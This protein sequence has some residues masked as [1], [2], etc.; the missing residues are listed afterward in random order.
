VKHRPVYQFGISNRGFG[1]V[2]VIVALAILVGIVT[3]TVFF[4]STFTTR[5]VEFGGKTSCQGLANAITTGLKSLENSLVV[6][7]WLPKYESKGESI[8]NNEDPFC[9]TKEG[10]KP[11]CDAFPLVA[12]EKKNQG[13]IDENTSQVFQNIRGTPVWAQSMYNKFRNQKICEGTGMVFSRSDFQNYLPMPLEIPTWVID[14]EIYIKD[15][16]L[17]CGD[18]STSRQAN[19]EFQVTPRYREARTPASTYDT[20]SSSITVA[21]LPDARSPIL[22]QPTPVLNV[23]GDEVQP[24]RCTDPRTLDQIAQNPDKRWDEVNFTL[25]VDEP[26]SILIARKD[27][28]FEEDKAGKFWNLQDMTIDGG[29]SISPGPQIVTYNEKLRATLVMGRMTDQ[30]GMSEPSALR[31]Y[32][33]QAIDTG[34]NK[35]GTVTTT[36]YAHQPVCA[37]PTTDYCP[38]AAPALLPPQWDPWKAYNSP[39]A[40]GL[41]PYDDC[42]NGLCPQGTHSICD[43]K[44]APLVCDGDKYQDDCGLAVCAGTKPK[45]CDGV[46]VSTVLCK[47]PAIGECGANCGIGTAPDCASTPDPATVACYQEIKDNC[48]NLCGIGKNNCPPCDDN[49]DPDLLPSCPDDDTPKNK[50]PWKGGWWGPFKCIRHGNGDTTTCAINISPATYGL[51]KGYRWYSVTFNARGH[52]HGGESAMSLWGQAWGASYNTWFSGIRSGR[53]LG[54][55]YVKNEGHPEDPQPWVT[56]NGT[57]QNVTLTTAG[58]AGGATFLFT[59]WVQDAEEDLYFSADAWD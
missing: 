15:T 31:S 38:N 17:K 57:W 19:L 48:G 28:K 37:R 23:K 49:D 6:R 39:T 42:L 5:T 18:E 36:F 51:P 9:S 43:K 33:F 3:A 35:S 16:G 22:T 59:L 29:L 4:S 27:G 21:N 50:P 32:T 20:C 41:R 24:G 2:E 45:S 56:A 26:G 12:T 58:G 47:K 46:D 13:Y 14:F 25:E 55:E 7:N 40:I 10:H 11:V 30:G 53:L 34:G 52:R 8:I 1:L 44:I 54:R